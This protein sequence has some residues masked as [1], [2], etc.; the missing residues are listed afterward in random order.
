ML[1]LKG[2]LEPGR[3]SEFYQVLHNYV[4]GVPSRF[5]ARP[6]NETVHALIES[7]WRYAGVLDDADDDKI[8]ALKTGAGG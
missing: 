7:A 3:R 5:D 4:R 2:D 6:D 1:V 8:L